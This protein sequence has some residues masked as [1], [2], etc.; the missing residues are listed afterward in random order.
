MLK[1]RLLALII[2]L[3]GIG[4]GY[5]VYSTEV[6]DAN[7][8]FAF[9]LGLDLSG[10]THLVYDADPAGIPENEVSDAMDALR[11]IIERR[12]NLFG[13][14][15]PVVQI[16]EAGVFSS[17]EKNKYRLIVELPGITDVASAVEMIGAT[18]TLEFK[19][20]RPEEE[21]KPIIEAYQKYQKDIEE[22]LEP[23]IDP[24]LFEEVYEPTGL[25]GRFLEKATLQFSGGA[26]GN[27]P[28]VL[29]RFNDEGAELF[30]K[31]TKEN[32]DKRLAIYLDGMPISEPVVRGEITGGEAIISGGFTGRDGAKEAKI[33]VGRLNSGALPVGELKLVS[34]QTIGPSL[35]VEAV[36]AG[37]EAGLFG[38]VLVALFLIV[39]YR[40]PGLL[41]VLSLCVYIVVVLT[42]FKLIPVTI[43][44]AGI[45]GFVL[46]IG[47]AVDANVLIFE[48]MREELKEGRSIHTAID[49]GFSRAWTSIRDGNTS[50]II[51]AIILFW[52]G[53]S[54]I[55][56]FALTFAIGIVA[57]MFSAIFTTK[58]FLLSVAKGENE[59]ITK[60]LLGSGFLN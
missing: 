27:E 20:E 3:S 29:L 6:T 53:T 14:S 56:G 46:S 57:S 48:R 49:E 30:A 18:P 24:L 44:A 32:I 11:D 60:F 8:R 13:V 54:L 2:L 50:S 19:K 35:G 12:V 47:M 59:G 21:V 5:F 26:T 45:A 38:L 36:K 43:T 28:S 7:S 1:I 34:T 10:G 31:I 39:W 33:L 22:G 55:Q 23:Q 15:E 40:L 37:V 41:A 42:L 16:E 9:K 51:T 17:E 58:I 52:F 25:T 4:V